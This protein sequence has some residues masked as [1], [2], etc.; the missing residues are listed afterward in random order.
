MEASLPGCEDESQSKWP[1]E[2][3][4]AKKNDDQKNNQF[5]AFPL[6]LNTLSRGA[7]TGR[8]HNIDPMDWNPRR[9]LFHPTESPAMTRFGLPHWTAGDGPEVHFHWVIHQY[10]VYGGCPL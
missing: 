1:E 8:R 2:R 10:G 5:S 9:D 4:D 7:D 3:N 6:W